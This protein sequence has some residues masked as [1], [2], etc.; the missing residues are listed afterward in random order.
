MLRV[1]GEMILS[2]SSVDGEGDFCLAPQ[3]LTAV[4]LAAKEWGGNRKFKQGP[5]LKE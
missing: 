4:Q 3:A 2:R 5:R 1:E